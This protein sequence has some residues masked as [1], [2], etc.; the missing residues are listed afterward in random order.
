[1]KNN[2]LFSIVLTSLVFS[3]AACN[4]SSTSVHE[5][6][7]SND[8]TYDETYHWHDATCGHTV[9]K[10][11][12]E[13]IFTDIVTPATYE[14]DGYTTHKCVI[15]GYSYTDSET[16][17]LVNLY[18]GNSK[19]YMRNITDKENISSLR[20]FHHKD[21]D[22]VPYVDMNEYH[23]AIRPYIE[24]SRSFYMGETDYE[25]V[26]SRVEGTGKMVFNTLNNTVTIINANAFYNDAI[27]TNNGIDG[28]MTNNN[29]KIYTGSEKTKILEKGH[30]VTIDLDDYDMDIVGQDHHLY[31]PINFINALL[32]A[33]ITAGISYNGADFFSDAAMRNRYTSVYARSGNYNSSWMFTNS[34]VPTAL[35]K[36]DNVL[37]DETY[38]FEGIFSNSNPDNPITVTMSLFNDHTGTLNSKTGIHYA[39]K[40]SEDETVIN[41]TGGQ[42]G[43]E[44]RDIEDVLSE[45]F[46]TKIN[47]KKTNYGLGKRS[48][49][50]A[51]MA[52][53]ELRLT[54]DY[55][56][57]L[58]E[59]NDIGKLISE[60]EEIKTALLSEDIMVYEDMVNKL[61]NH[62][63]DD[64]HSSMKG[65][66]SVYSSSPINSF[67]IEKNN[68]YQGK[69]NKAYYDEVARLA[70]MKTNSGNNQTYAISGDT[71]YLR[72]HIFI[73]S[74][75][76]NFPIL[77]YTNSVYKTASYEEAQAKVTSALNDAPY[78][79]FAVA[80]NDIVK[81]ENIKNVVIDVT[82]NIGGEIRCMPY[83]AAFLTLDPS[84]VYRNA[85]DGSLI[86]LHYKVDLNG[87]GTFGGTGD[88]FEGKYKF[89]VLSGAN[90]SAGNEFATLAKNTGMAKLLGEKSSGGSCAIANHVDSSGLTYTISSVFDMQLKKG[91]AYV[92]NDDGVDID[93]QLPFDNWYELDKL[94]AFLK[95]LA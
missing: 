95:T 13:H 12:A 11:K 63:V 93:Y 7:F 15:C 10:G 22:D 39:F 73:H 74:I 75:N 77:P 21:Y 60:N 28:D 18:D 45:L 30:D 32:M 70:M 49:A 37:S 19:Y 64:I 80:F 88:S 82:G 14:K 53:D 47:K 55:I 69:R 52:Y 71:A 79:A 35:K 84:I 23:Y 86:D 72:F 46:T 62:Y 68:E 3:L 17:R 59:K 91:D 36:V 43:M 42:T 92:T 20:T 4:A 50:V 40:W 26:Y 83:L 33:P 67:I 29:I 78:Y 57:G 61:I 65:G 89:Y 54:F 34:E 87:D 58:K 38:R 5:H 41:L 6:T 25:F 90:F 16:R 9:V 27:G 56:Y 24:R 8:W 94:D 48:K 85:L 44:S 66:E 81:H 51:K 1:M 76:P 2:K 31:V